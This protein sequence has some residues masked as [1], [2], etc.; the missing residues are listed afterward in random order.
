MKYAGFWSR[1]LAGLIDVVV[2]MPL[3]Y[4]YT[5]IER[6]SYVGTMVFVIPYFL[7]YAGYNIFLLAKYGQTL[8]KMAVRIKVTRTD[9]SDIGIRE[10][11][12]RHSVDFAFALISAIGMLIAIHATGSDVFTSEYT[13]IERN[14]M[15]MPNTPD[16]ANI[17]QTLSN[18]WVWSELLVLLFNK[19][20]RALHDFIAGTVVV[21]VAKA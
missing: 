17:A 16:F 21:H 3:F 2:F 6:H 8:G 20:R 1:F 11:I 12:L 5:W 9:G 18:I 14:K 10:A 4:L 7:T 13:W 19:K 15:I